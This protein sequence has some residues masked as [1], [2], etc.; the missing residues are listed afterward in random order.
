MNETL[1]RIRIAP[2]I[3]GEWFYIPLIYILI[4]CWN[5]LN[6]ISHPSTV[7][8]YYPNW[9]KRRVWPKN[10]LKNLNVT[11]LQSKI[12]QSMAQNNF[13]L[14]KFV[15]NKVLKFIKLAFPL[16]Y[17][18]FSLSIW[19]KRRVLSENHY[20]NLNITI[21]RSRISQTFSGLLFYIIQHITDKVMK[22]FH[23]ILFKLAEKEYYSKALS[24]K[25]E[26]F[27]LTN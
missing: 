5:L 25:F 17:S 27:T 13:I 14:P 22:M 26:C 20:K 8:S 19:E 21:L 3:G 7:F 11:L 23:S 24:Q 9:L 12:Y 4:R 6:L 18:I 15:T 2:T 1:S 10:H 16:F